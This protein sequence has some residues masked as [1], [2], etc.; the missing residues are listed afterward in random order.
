MHGN[1]NC[2]WKIVDFSLH[3]LHLC[4]CFSS[5]CYISPFQR[6]YLHF[7]GHNSLPPTPFMWFVKVFKLVFN[8]LNKN[9]KKIK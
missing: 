2:G 5:I 7:Y 9:T 1:K 6:V 8:T 3:S 4:F